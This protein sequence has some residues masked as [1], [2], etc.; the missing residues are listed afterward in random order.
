MTPPGSQDNYHTN[1][2]WT[3][4]VFAIPL[5]LMSEASKPAE[6]DQ[7]LSTPQLCIDIV[8]DY[9]KEL[10]SKV[11]TVKSILVAFEES[12]AYQNVQQD[13]IDA[14]IGTYI[15]M[16]NQHN[17]TQRLATIHRERSGVNDEQLEEERDQTLF[18]T[19]KRTHSE[20]P[21]IQMSSKK[22]SPDK[23]LFAW[24]TNDDAS[25]TVLTFSQELTHKLV[26]NHMLDLK[27]S[28][29]MVLRSRCV[30]EF[31]DSEWNNVLAG[32]VVNLD[33]VFSGMYLTVMDN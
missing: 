13:Q 22:C 30:P 9:A 7:P 24:L 33:V 16:L 11:V 31:P 27:A 1:S 8:R 20:S 23:S 17:A 21:S 29:C 2:F 25:T 18:S 26:Q 10:F 28:K 15:A 14:T 3:D 12:S 32:K 5:Y 6:N 19:S 4:S